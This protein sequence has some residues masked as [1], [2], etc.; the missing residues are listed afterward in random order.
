MANLTNIIKINETDYQTLADGGS[1]VKDGQTYTFDANALYLVPDTSTSV[2]VEIPNDLGLNSS[3]LY[4]ENDSG[5]IGTGINLTTLKSNLGLTN[6]VTS[7]NTLTSGR[8]ILGGGNRT[9]S[10]SSYTIDTSKLS[11]SLYIPTSYVVQNAI[12]DAVNGLSLSITTTTTNAVTGINGGSG[13]FTL[14]VTTS[15]T[16][17]TTSY[18]RILRLSHTHTAASS[19]GTAT[20]VTGISGGTITKA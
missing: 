8:I 10:S 6:A 16:A 5:Q 20:V 3:L 18:R 4:L 9:I 14:T 17:N 2:T 1:V 19:K 13:N 11:G 7:A 15:G 12:D